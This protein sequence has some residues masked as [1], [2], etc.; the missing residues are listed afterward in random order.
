MIDSDTRLVMVSLKQVGNPVFR[1][2]VVPVGCYCLRE[3]VVRLVGLVGLSN[4]PALVG[5]VGLAGM[6][7]LTSPL[8]LV[9]LV[10]LVDCPVANSS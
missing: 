8:T 7:G 4:P 6:V 10:D 3:E 5:R 2:L 1:Q 9:G